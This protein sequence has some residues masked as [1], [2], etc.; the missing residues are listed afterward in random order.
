MNSGCNKFCLQ[1][2][3]T[4]LCWLL[5]AQLSL[6]QTKKAAFKL[7]DN[8]MYLMVPKV[9]SPSALDSFAAS[10]NIAGIGL[11]QL[12]L[13]GK[14]DSLEASGW[15][16]NRNEND[17]YIITKPLGSATNLKNPAGRIIFSAIPT[18]DNWRVMG[19]NKVVYGVNKFKSRREFKQENGLVYF[20]LKGFK[21]ANEVRLAG[22]FTNW[23]YGAFPM[24]RSDEGWMV[25]VR[26]SPGPHY[27]KFIVNKGHWTTDPE[28]E[29][30]ENDGRG[31]EN[32][33]FYVTNKTF[34]LQG[35]PNAWNVYLSG[36]FNNWSKDNLRMEKIQTG[37][38]IDLYL[39]P[40]THRYHYIVDGK[41]IQEGTRNKTPSDSASTM[42]I[43]EPYRF[44]LK[45][46]SK[47]RRV[48]VAGNFNDW[49]P[50]E[51]FMERTNEG[52]QLPYALGA[53]NYQYK[54]LV[55]GNWITD[56]ANPSIVDDGKGNENSFMVIGAN[57]DFRLKG[58]ATAKSVQLSG[59]FIDWSERGLPMRRVGNEWIFPVY[60]A[61]GKHLYKFIVDGKW[62]LDP[63]NKFWEENEL[64]TGNS[65]VWIE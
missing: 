15:T 35:Y 33:L 8:T 54:F 4:F 49:R 41:T 56:P 44:S 52:W 28:N 53:G 20:V 60:L 2:L 34:L 1:R 3:I 58:Y 39:E 65:V 38:K 29:L 63:S 27:Y 32:S 42:A 43:G 23:Q 51:L 25:T 21:T 22:D 6:S 40:G 57:Y 30:S 10:Y 11:H 37:W 61:R 5:T 7:K 12:L 36:S 59:D 50:N 62:I 47:A 16:I 24:E 55:D 31:N 14:G 26:L 64:G 9:L 48:A 18:P 13:S 17:Q 19:G 45:G 46:F